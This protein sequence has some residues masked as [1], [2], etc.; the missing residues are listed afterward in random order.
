MYY[1]CKEYPAFTPFA[2]EEEEATKVFSLFN[3]TYKL[4]E[5]MEQI[6]EEQ[7]PREDKII[8]V[9]ANDNDGWW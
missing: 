8:R 1:L 6:K 5:Q 9:P 3:D 7:E 4:N 2:I